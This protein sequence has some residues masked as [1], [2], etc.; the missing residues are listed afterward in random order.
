M[1]NEFSI[2]RLC[3]RVYVAEA[4][5]RRGQ[6]FAFTLL[7]WAANARRRA[8]SE[9]KQGEMFANLTEAREERAT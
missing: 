9:P 4:R 3:A 5:R 1:S 7:E 6:P 8:A 2:N